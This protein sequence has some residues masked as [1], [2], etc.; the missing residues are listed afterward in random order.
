MKSK[1]KTKSHCQKCS[2]PH[3]GYDVEKDKCQKCG[4]PLVPGWLNESYEPGSEG[5]EQVERKGMWNCPDPKC[6]AQYHGFVRG[7]KCEK[8]GK[9]LRYVIGE[10]GETT[11]TT[12]AKCGETFDFSKQKEAA[13]GAVKCPKCGSLVSQ[14]G[15]LIGKQSEGFHVKR[16]FGGRFRLREQ[17]SLAKQKEYDLETD[18]I[19]KNKLTPASSLPHKFVKAQWFSLSGY[20]RCLLCGMDQPYYDECPG[21][22]IAKDFLATKAF[23]DKLRAEHGNKGMYPKEEFDRV[24]KEWTLGYFKQRLHG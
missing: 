12:C 20:P 16:L 15:K 7:G 18:K 9:R 2:E 22:E 5:Q 8:C 14:S 21:L 11:L 24:V 23:Y 19:N 10:A 6:G 3:W 13:P 1:T 4:S 17:L